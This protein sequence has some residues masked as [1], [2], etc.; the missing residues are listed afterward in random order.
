MQLYDSTFLLCSWK[1]PACFLWDLTSFHTEWFFFMSLGSW[2]NW[3]LCFEIHVLTSNDTALLLW[4]NSCQITLQ[5]MLWSA[6]TFI[7]TVMFLFLSGLLSSW[8]PPGRND[9]THFRSVRLSMASEESKAAGRWWGECSRRVITLG[10]LVFGDT[11]SIVSVSSIYSKL[12]LPIP[13]E[14]H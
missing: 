4:Y 5:P 3:R 8:L 6:Q 14:I 12:F 2:D 7:F 1:A 10:K 9:C 13:G 11:C